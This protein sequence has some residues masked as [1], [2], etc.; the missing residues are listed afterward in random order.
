MK[1]ALLVDELPTSSAPKIVGEEAYHLERLGVRCDIYV[2]KHRTGEISPPHMKDIKLIHV[3]KNLG[4]FGKMCGLRVPSFSFFSLYHIAYPYILSRR[5]SKELDSYDVVIA[6]FAS[7]AIFASRLSLQNATLAFY[8]HDPIS[9]IFNEAYKASWSTIKRKFLSLVASLIDEKLLSIPDIII[10]QSR[11][12]YKRILQLSSA[13]LIKIVYPGVEAV[14]KIPERRKNYALAVNRWE[15][16]KNPFFIIEVAKKL[17]ENLSKFKILMV[18]PWKTSSLL[19]EFV[20]KAKKEGVHENFRILGPVEEQ[21]LKNFYLNARCLIHAKTEAFGLTG[22]EAAAHGCPII[23]PK[24]SGV[25][26]LFT[27]GIHGYFPKESDA[28]DYAEY[29]INLLNDERLAW[30]MGYEAWKV[31]KY[32]SWKHHAKNLAEVLEEFVGKRIE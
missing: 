15:R 13:R 27:H 5:L 24:D 17:R 14:N 2:L 28:K 8:Y 20:R 4:L 23:F 19:M 3:D 11:F 10:L 6:H 31:S 9:Y 32:Y 29:L 1:V 12:H 7:T 18:G 26:E 16:G 30:K 21:K 25:T 22:L